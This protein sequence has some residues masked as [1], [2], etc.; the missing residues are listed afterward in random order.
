MFAFFPT[1]SFFPAMLL[2]PKS[3]SRLPSCK[4]YRLNQYFALPK[5]F[6]Y[7]LR[8]YASPQP[9]P[10]DNSPKPKPP[11]NMTLPRPH[12]S[13]KAQTAP[14]IPLQGVVPTRTTPDPLNPLSTTHPPPLSLPFRAPDLP[15]YKYYFR[16]GKAYAQFYKTG[17]KAIYT[18][19][20]LARALP[21]GLYYR[22]QSD[23][24]A[25]VEDGTLNR[26][27]FQLIRRA[28]SDVNKLPLFVLVWLVCGEFTPLVVIFVSGLVP[29]VIWIPK[30]VQKAREK[31][32]TRRKLAREESAVHITG[33]T[34][35]FIIDEMV[36]PNR[37]NT[38]RYYARSM[39]LYPGLWDRLPPAVIPTSLVKNRVQNRIEYLEIDDLA[40]AMDGGERRMNAQEITWAC[41]D[42][43]IDAL[44]KEERQ[45]RT[46]LKAWLETR[47]GSEPGSGY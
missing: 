9:R 19:W 8:N 1:A 15:A 36:E 16:L 4:S 25:A 21:D 6:H 17:L 11:N 10:Y 41:E 18:N 20:K 12:T 3:T 40:I 29:R 31:A 30:Q 35:L 34:K 46:D 33:P 38:Y 37:T 7:P 47:R 13:P 28:K 43:G 39:G 22:S 23:L 42:R 14:I 32:E 27:D 24:R 44:G 5:P 45:L 2:L 26:A